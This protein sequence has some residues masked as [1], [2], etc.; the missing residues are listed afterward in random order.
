MPLET[1]KDPRGLPTIDCIVVR[2]LLRAA[3]IGHRRIRLCT[4][5]HL[6]A[7]PRLLPDVGTALVN[8]MPQMHVPSCRR[9]FPLAS[10]ICNGTVPTPPPPP[11]SQEICRKFNENRCFVRRC[12]Y[13][14]IC[15]GCG[16]PHPAVFCSSTAGTPRPVQFTRDRS[17]LGQHNRMLRPN[18]Q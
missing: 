10:S 7:M 8:F 6:S 15:Q 5:R 4:T 3:L 18:R 11:P 14:H 2:P 9:P 13:Q 17:P 12:K 1:T 16:H